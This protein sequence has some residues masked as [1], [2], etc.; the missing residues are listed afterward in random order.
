MLQEEEAKQLIFEAIKSG[1]IN[2]LGSGST[3]DLCVIRKNSVDYLRPYD[4][5]CN[6]GVKEGS[7]K[8]KKGTTAVL[9]SIVRPVIVEDVSV[10]THEQ[11]PM[12]I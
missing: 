5:T 2:D 9:T 1:V 12:D 6:K 7:Y 10:R 4:I 11:E 3:V 8:F